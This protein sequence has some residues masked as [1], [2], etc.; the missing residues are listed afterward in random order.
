[1]SPI[2]NHIV[3]VLVRVAPVRCAS[4]S[5]TTTELP[6]LCSLIALPSVNRRIS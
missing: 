2:S 3:V 1:M 5:G 6:I 4:E